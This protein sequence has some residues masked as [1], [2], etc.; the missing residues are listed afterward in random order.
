MQFFF[1]C[2]L[3]LLALC[4][5]DFHI[6]ECNTCTKIDPPNIG[7]NIGPNIAE[8]GKFYIADCKNC[9]NATGYWPS[10]PDVGGLNYP[11]AEHTVRH[12]GHRHKG[13]RRHRGMRRR[14]SNQENMSGISNNGEN[15][16][17]NADGPFSGEFDDS[18]RNRMKRATFARLS[19]PSSQ[20]TTHP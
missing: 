15:F 1:L 20:Q 5:G 3:S 16:L 7:P 17:P 4:S 18:F 2:V 8:R 14:L 6:S 10:I 12:T 9:T 19:K 13:M 11:T